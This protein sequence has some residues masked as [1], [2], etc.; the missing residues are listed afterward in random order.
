MKLFPNFI[1]SI[2]NLQ[3]PTLQLRSNTRHKKQANPWK[4]VWTLLYP[5]S[6]YR[7][8]KIN[9]FSSQILRANYGKEMQQVVLEVNF[10]FT[11]PNPNIDVLPYLMWS[12]PTSVCVS[13]ENVFVFVCFRGDGAIL[14]LLGDEFE[15]NV[16]MWVKCSWSSIRLE[17]FDENCWICLLWVSIRLSSDL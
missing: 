4:C 13:D 17:M 10:I 16:G 14:S 9:F 12:P 5:F 11:S 2:S 7:A 3:F 6:D 1:W 8:Q 15:L